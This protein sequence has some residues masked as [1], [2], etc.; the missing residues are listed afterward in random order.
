[1]TSANPFQ[2]NTLNPAVL[3]A[4]QL[5]A[6]TLTSQLDPRGLG[7]REALQS[8]GPAFRRSI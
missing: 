8:T 3:A 6:Q 4:S 2:M 5:V 1:M 7:R